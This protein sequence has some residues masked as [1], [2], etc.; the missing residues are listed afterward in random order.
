MLYDDDYKL[1]V[2]NQAGRVDQPRVAGTHEAVIGDMRNDE[3]NL[4]S[5]LHA[6]LLTFYNAVYDAQPDPRPGIAISG[7]GNWCAGRISMSWSMII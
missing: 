2:F 6:T 3:N 4:I 5:Q 7:R 1:V